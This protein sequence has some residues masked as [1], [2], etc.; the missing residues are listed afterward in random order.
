MTTR[1]YLNYRRAL[2]LIQA[3]DTHLVCS[4]DRLFLADVA[5]E[6]LLC[7]A[8]QPVGAQA[9]RL[10]DCLGRLVDTGA[11]PNALAEELWRTIEAAGP[12]DELPPAGARA[13]RLSA[14]GSR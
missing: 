5:E 6:L 2:D 1:R 4:E 12:E 13:R 11:L 10:G 14:A 3:L 8:E 7:R 9:D